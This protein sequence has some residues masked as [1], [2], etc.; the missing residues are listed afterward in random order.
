MLLVGL[1][2]LAIAPAPQVAPPASP[3]QSAP[4]PAKPNAAKVSPD[5]LPVSL[6]RIQRALARTPMLRFDAQNKPVF[7]VQVFGD[8]PTIDEILGPASTGPVPH[9]SLSHQ[10]FLKMVTPDEAQGYAGFTNGEGVTV[11]TTSL[12]LQWTLQKA[13]HKFRE[14]RDERAREAARQEVLQAL[15][16]LEKARAK[17]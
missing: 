4:A 11:A 8:E 12:L 1:L 5:D 14:T 10:E 6:D 3:P 7:R 9:G 13:I 17:K 16:A 2:L 15:E